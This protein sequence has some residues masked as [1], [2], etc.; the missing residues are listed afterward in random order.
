MSG[1]EIVYLNGDFMP[2][3]EARISPLD[4]GFLF[5]DGVYEMIPAYAGVLFRLEEHLAR[6]QRSLAE[7]RIANPMSDAQWQSLFEKLIEKN[8]SGNL[9][10]YLQITRGA[11]GKRDHAFPP[12][13]TAATVFAMT[14]AIAAPPADSPESTPGVSAVTFDDTRWARCDIKSISLLPNI[15]LRQEAIDKGAQEAIMLRDGFVTEGAASNVFVVLDNTI[16][17][18]PKSHLILGGITRDLVL[19]LCQ[20]HGLPWVEREINETELTRASEIW[21]T[22]STREVVPVVTLNRQPVGDGKPGPLWKS[23]AQHYVNFKRE[24]CGA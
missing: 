22:S 9:G 2:L 23:L 6:L 20:Q 11:T 7:I 16:V 17:T 14:S 10:V 18:P 24:L 4:R 3:D 21:V 5:A 15:L 12:A 13:D 19:E 1:N 8:G